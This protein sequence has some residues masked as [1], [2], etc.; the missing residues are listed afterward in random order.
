M[1]SCF[2][3]LLIEQLHIE[4]NENIFNGTSWSTMALLLN[5]RFELNVDSN[6]L[7]ARYALLM[8]QH[9]EIT[10][11]LNS[12]GFTWDETQSVIIAENGVWDDYSK[13]IF[14]KIY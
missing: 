1:E 13:V 9:T 4:N 2:I 6:V 11:I 14:C 7:E 3:S 10:Q 5:Q 8:K 12:S